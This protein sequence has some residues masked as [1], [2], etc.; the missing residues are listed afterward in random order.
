MDRDQFGGGE[1]VH[2][3][4]GHRIAEDQAADAHDEE[5][6]GIQPEAYDDGAGHAEQR[7]DAEAD[8]AADPLHQ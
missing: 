4:A 3:Q 7:T 6:A 2:L 1:A 5:I 8:A